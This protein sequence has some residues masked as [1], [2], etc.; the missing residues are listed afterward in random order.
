MDSS[1][2]YSL[3]FM[4]KMMASTSNTNNENQHSYINTL[5]S[6]LLMTFMPMI[7][8]MFRNIDIKEIIS[9]F[10][11][12]KNK[13]V[14]K[15]IPF[16]EYQVSK[17]SF[18]APL[19]KVEYSDKFKAI[20]EYVKTLSFI[21]LSSQEIL[22]D[23]KEMFKY[24]EN[25]NKNSS[26]NK[27]ND[28]LYTHTKILID[29]ERLIY[30]ELT[31]DKIVDDENDKKDSNKVNTKSNNKKFIIVLSILKQPNVNSCKILNDFIEE[32][33]KLYYDK[34]NSIIDDDKLYVFTYTGC[35]KSEN[36]IQF[37]FD[38]SEHD[39]SV[40][41]NENVFFDGRFD[42]INYLSD[43]VY[44]PIT[45]KSR[46]YE[47]FK[48]MGDKVQ[49]SVI[50]YGPPGE[51]KTTIMKAT[52]KFLGRHLVKYSLSQ[53][54]TND[55]MDQ[56]YSNTTFCNITYSRHQL[57]FCSEDIDAY[58][59][60][61]TMSRKNIDESDINKSEHISETIILSKAIEDTCK[62]MK[63]EDDKPNLQ[64]FLN[65]TDG[66]RELT[67]IF[68]MFSTNYFEKLDSALVRDGRIDIK[69]NLT[70][71]SRNIIKQILKHRF[72][73]H[74]VNKY[75]ENKNIP[76]GIVS[77]ATIIKICK[78]NHTDI[79]KCINDIEHEC[80]SIIK[81]LSTH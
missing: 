40:D 5:M 74:C 48:K 66:I 26:I 78:L 42:Y 31:E 71:P 72:K 50:A 2:L 44:D 81:G 38:K 46:G 79:Y 6:I 14:T 11:N 39:P 18:T 77:T 9:D 70:P 49:G 51:G 80:S 27:Y 53:F 4:N 13:Y 1:S 55:E 15:T 29:K 58:N 8:N 43:F 76:D 64:T 28:V 56:F 52:P 33:L 60:N 22:S 36:S 10:F 59:D 20:Q 47:K 16:H 3:F 57:C 21:D 30:Y 19:L 45:K 37:F 32:C 62:I 12:G 17:G 61:L 65:I 41:L 63:L 54:K 67:G 34:Q 7:S 24:Y 73:V 25:E 35:E 23:N 75:F 68:F 69:L